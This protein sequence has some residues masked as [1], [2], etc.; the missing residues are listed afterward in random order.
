MGLAVLFIVLAF[1]AGVMLGEKVA[2]RAVGCALK[3]VIVGQ[4]VPK[5]VEKTVETILSKARRARGK[6]G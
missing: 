3:T 4:I 6:N 5:T 1:G 2:R